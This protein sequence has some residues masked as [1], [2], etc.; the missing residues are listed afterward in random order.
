MQTEDKI[1]AVRD[2]LKT[3]SKL[4]LDKL[5]SAVSCVIYRSGWHAEMRIRIARSDG[6][7]GVKQSED[8]SYA[9]LADVATAYRC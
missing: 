4:D 8:C 6:G 2:G 5:I 9:G 1:Q 7:Q 3:T